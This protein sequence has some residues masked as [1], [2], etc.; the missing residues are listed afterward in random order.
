MKCEYCGTRCNKTCF[1]AQFATVSGVVLAV[2]VVA[3][4]ISIA[5]A[6][7]SA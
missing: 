4:L 7:A 3:A 5:V 2:S 6:T 1:G